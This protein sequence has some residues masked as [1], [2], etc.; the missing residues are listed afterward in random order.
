M[1]VGFGWVVALGLLAILLY[2]TFSVSDVGDFLNIIQSANPIWVVA[3]AI[4]EISTYFCTA[5]MYQ[6]MLKGLGLKV[7]FRKLLPLSMEKLAV[8]QFIPTAGVGGSTIVVH[9]LKRVGASRQ[10]AIGM[11]VTGLAAWYIAGDLA[12]IFGLIMVK[13]MPV[14]FSGGLTIFGLYFLVS[15]FI[16]YV[17]LHGVRTR[18]FEKIKRLLPG[19]SLDTFFAEMAQTHDLGLVT[20][21]GL[22]KVVVFQLGIILLDA[23][24]LAF[25]CLALGTPVPYIYALAGYALANMAA[26]ITVLPGGIGVFEG[27]SVAVLSFLGMTPAAA[28]AAVVLYRGLSVWLPLIPGV[29]MARREI[30]HSYFKKNK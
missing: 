23:G 24:T 11:V 13:D 5:G 29:L 19:K 7:P 26:T 28:L 6:V 18:A 10:A 1:L 12:G 2:Y 21:L 17:T 20:K 16:I 30:H 14:A 3:M 22:S 8:D 9:G 27:G 4:T 15:V 25:A